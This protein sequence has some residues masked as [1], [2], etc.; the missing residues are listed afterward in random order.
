MAIWAD[1][2]RI[3]SYS[4]ELD[5]LEKRAKKDRRGAGI[6]LPDAMPMPGQD[7]SM[8]GGGRGTV[9][10]RDSK[11]FID[12]S[13]ITN[14]S[15]RYKEYE[16]LRN[17]PE[18]EMAMEIYADEAC[19]I[20]ENG[21]IFDVQ[22]NNEHVKEELEW[23]FFHRKMLNLDDPTVGWNLVKKLFIFGDHFAELIINPENPKDGILGMMDLPCESMYRIETTQGKLIEFQQS[24]EGPDYQSLTRAPVPQATESEIMQ[25][26]ALRFTAEQLIHWRVGDERKT[27]YPYGVSLIEAARGPAHQLRL[28]EDAMVVYRLTRAPERRVFYIDVGTLSPSRAEAFVDRI[29]SQFRKR[30]IATAQHAGKGGA[31]AAEERWH[32]PAQDED[33]W[34]PTRPNSNTK[35]D[36]LPGAQNLGEIDD[37]LYFRNKLFTALKFPKSYFSN[38][39]VQVTRVSLSAQDVKFARIIE[40]LQAHIAAGFMQLAE[41]HLTLIGVPEDDYEDLK[42]KFTPPS[43]WRELTRQEIITARIN[44]ASSVKGS[45]IMSD[46]DIS[47]KIM[48]YSEDETEEMQAR[49]KVQKL[50]DFKLQVLAQN[51]ELLGVGTPGEDENEMGTEPGGPNP[52]LGPEAGGTPP[53]GGPL[54]GPVPGPGGAPSPGGPPMPPPPDKQMGQ[55]GV[56]PKATPE[57]IK[58]YDLEIQNYDLEIDVEPVDYS[59]T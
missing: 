45:M 20:G 33:Y 57:E 22:A 21:H 42:I 24:N 26:T 6:T 59:E 56:I 10:L 43:D 1:L 11:D 44:N 7:G 55:G 41:R 23:L 32:P 37:A 35:I 51:P 29:K 50:E 14:R 54:P 40:R 36:T 48:K 58:K 9:R 34:L 4:F 17:V 39:D 52:M 46:F 16:R 27:F 53:M 13:T 28:M 25:T 49:M 15:S 8:A 2:F 12:L 30:K 38:E 19:Q 31:A 5:P 47:T 3:W 18:I